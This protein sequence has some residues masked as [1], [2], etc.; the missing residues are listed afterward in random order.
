MLIVSR[1]IYEFFFF[2][3]TFNFL[4][5]SSSRLTSLRTLVWNWICAYSR[6]RSQKIKFRTAISTNHLCL[7]CRVLCQR[8]FHLC[9]IHFLSGCN[10]AL[11]FKQLQASENVSIQTKLVLIVFTGLFNVVQWDDC[12]GDFTVF[13]L[14]YFLKYETAITLDLCAA[15]VSLSYINKWNYFLLVQCVISNIR[16]KISDI[17]FL[18]WNF[19]YRITM[20]PVNWGK[21]GNGIHS[22]FRYYVS[23]LLYL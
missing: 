15:Y 9:D 21:Y 5:K 22:L 14:N 2:C 8:K 4:G 13:F 1:L 19:Q 16:Y 7:V 23:Q 20:A 12:N 18:F 11:K 3:A 10:F 6:L 17:F